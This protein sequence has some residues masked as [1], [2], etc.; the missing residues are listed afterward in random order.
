MTTTSTSDDT[1]ALPRRVR[2]WAVASGL[3]GIGVGSLATVL[4]IGHADEPSQDPASVRLSDVGSACRDWMSSGGVAD[5]DD[6]RWCTDMVDWMDDH[7]SGR[8]G[9][10]MMHDR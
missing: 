9:T 1:A 10:W 8:T 5:R 2:R 7:L 3:V 4:V 6:Q